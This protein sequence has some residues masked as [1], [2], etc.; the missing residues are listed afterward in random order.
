MGDA[1]PPLISVIIPFLNAEPFIKEAIESVFAQTYRTWEAILVDDGSTDGSTAIARRYAD[2]H[3]EQVQYLEHEGH[4]N[5]GPSAARNLG[6]LHS[7]GQY[8]AFL[9][10]DDVWLPHKL[11]QQVT[12]LEARPEAGMLYGLSRWW[13]SWTGNPQ[14]RA[15]D[16]VYP[17]GL[18]AG[19]VQSPPAMIT[20]FFITQEAT[21]PSPTSVMVRRS[22]VE[23]LGGFDESLRG[24]FAVYEDQAFYAKVA[25]AAPIL[26]SDICWD[27]Y[28]QH[29]DSACSIVKKEG[30]EI[31]T[32]IFFLNWLLRYIETKG[33]KGTDISRALRKEIWSYRYPLLRRLLDGKYMSRSQLKHLLWRLS[34]GILPADVRA[35][36]WARWRHQ[37]YT[38]PVG[39]VHLGSLRRTTPLSREFGYDRGLPV[40]RYYIRQFLAGHSSDIRGRVLEI[41][42]DNYTRRF[43]GDRVT[44]SDVLHLQPDAPGA[45][46]I[47]DLT[48]ADHIPS[49]SFDC[50]ILTQTLQFIENVQAALQTVHRILAPGGVVLATF[51][52]ISHISRYDMDRWGQ[53]W[54]FT[55]LSARRLF[56]QAFPSGQVQV[57]TYGNVLATTAFL[58]GM[59]VEDLTPGDLEVYDPDYELIVAVRAVRQ[60]LDG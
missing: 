35:W 22:V 53:F 20:R 46:L 16:F 30:Q 5:R 31:R 15:R 41:A 12:M 13:Y 47:G 8:L 18:P 44:R 24:P 27:Y 3:P 2:Q 59:A 49:D 10:A 7:K 33:L 51:P 50:V 25:L 58:F 26:A 21:I 40:D 28:R 23:K 38:P 60:V 57:C 34:R 55:S 56:E 1:K 45:T 48:R 39:S 37:I 54:S 19:A 36:L 4:Q 32:R 17:L 9:D 42:D 6:I 29:P 52:G 14:D 43:G 11:E